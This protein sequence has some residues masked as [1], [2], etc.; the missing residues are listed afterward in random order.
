MVV[1]D[2]NKHY[3]HFYRDVNVNMCG[4]FVHK[5]VCLLV[6]ILSSFVEQIVSL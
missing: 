3:T 1:C 5:Y 6:G 2:N 4:V